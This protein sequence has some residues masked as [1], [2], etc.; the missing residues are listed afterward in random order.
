MTMLSAHFS[1]EELTDTHRVIDNTPTVDA[2]ENLKLLVGTLEEVHM[3]L[4]PAHITSGYRCKALNEA[5]GGQSSSQHM[6]GLAADFIC[7]RFSLR[8]AARRILQ[9]HI[10]F[11]QFIYEYGSWLHISH[12]PLGH[13]G[14]GEALMVG[15]FTGGKYL[16]L[17][18]GKTG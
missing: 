8:E 18:L 4:G 9:Q 13:L 17:D 6:Q 7:T 3:L 12:P 14:R 15:K 5:V 11:D 2:I 1:L 16:P 10:A